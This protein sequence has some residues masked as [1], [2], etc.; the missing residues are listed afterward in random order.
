MQRC[1]I[2]VARVARL[3]RFQ[4]YQFIDIVRIGVPDVAIGVDPDL[5][6][7]MHRYYGLNVVLMAENKIAHRFRFRLAKRRGALIDFF[8]RIRTRSSFYKTRVYKSTKSIAFDAIKVLCAV[9]KCS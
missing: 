4:H 3:E 9:S 2:R 8:A 6:I 5:R 1:V 7:S